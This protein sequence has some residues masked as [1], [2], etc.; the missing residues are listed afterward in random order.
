M[1]K[2]KFKR[3][4]RAYF[5]SVFGGSFI[6]LIL[7]LVLSQVFLGYPF[8]LEEIIKVFYVTI[9]LYLLP[10]LLFD[11][12]YFLFNGEN[13]TRLIIPHLICSLIY[14][15]ITVNA[16]VDGGDISKMTILYFII[17]LSTGI[18]LFV[19]YERVF[20]KE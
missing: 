15:L 6:A 2:I 10:S 8:N 12:F 3:K 13:R 4:L 19:N 9:F 17:S 1:N 14:L 11:L 7:G 16:W 18:Y 5:L 20:V